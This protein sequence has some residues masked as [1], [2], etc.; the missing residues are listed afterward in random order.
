M[1]LI[2]TFL[3]APSWPLP[4]LVAVIEELRP[5]GGA[6]LDR[7]LM[8]T[9]TVALIANSAATPVIDSAM[10]R[11]IAH[12]TKRSRPSLPAEVLFK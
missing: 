10:Y 9:D 12:I 1:A 2:W 3:M 6:A 11:G 8:L 4:A 5:H 7:H